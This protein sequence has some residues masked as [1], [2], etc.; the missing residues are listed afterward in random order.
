MSLA[1]IE[2]RAAEFMGKHKGDLAALLAKAEAKLIE[3]GHD[4]TEMFGE[5]AASALEQ[6]TD[7]EIT[8][9]APA[10]TEPEVLD[11]HGQ[12]V[13]SLASGEQS[14]A[15]MEASQAIPIGERG[16]PN[17][18]AATI[19]GADAAPVEPAKEGE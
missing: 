14:I 6:G 3:L 9:V 8:D 4:V 2:A 10:S 18:P 5:P 17:E 19:E 13:P 1:T 11:E 7:P 12:W 16:A 15:Y